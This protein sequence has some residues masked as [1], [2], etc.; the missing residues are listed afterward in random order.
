MLSHLSRGMYQE[1]GLG[2]VNQMKRIDWG[3]LVWYWLPLLL[4]ATGI[5]YLSS[6]SAPQQELAV[7]LNSV[8][9]LIPAEGN[10][11]FAMDDKV[12]HIIEYAL[13]A[14]LTFRAFRYSRKG[15]SDVSVAM[16]TVGF[17]VVIC[18]YR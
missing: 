7:F 2:G 3:G 4:V 6:L 15:R 14:V 9:A 1:Q 13:L 5:I 11:V 10:I 16:L 17:V 18:L 12:Y 8:N